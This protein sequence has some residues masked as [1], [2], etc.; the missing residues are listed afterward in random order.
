MMTA[1]AMSAD[2]RLSSLLRGLQGV[3]VKRDIVV[4]QGAG[5]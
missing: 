4:S 3:N 2:H 1:E 5:W